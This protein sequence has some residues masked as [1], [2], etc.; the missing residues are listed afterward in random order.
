M[1]L[2]S[3]ALLQ[4]LLSYLGF[5]YPGRGL[6]LYSC[7][8]KAHSLLLT[9]DEGYL[10]TTAPPDL[11]CGIAPQGPPASTK[12]QNH[13]ISPLLSSSTANQ[14]SDQYI[15]Y[16]FNISQ[17]YPHCSHCISCFLYFMTELLPLL[18]CRP[19]PLGSLSVN[20]CYSLI[21]DLVVPKY[22]LKTFFCYTHCRFMLKYGK[23]NT[24][25]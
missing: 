10:L 21:V 23:T 8:S 5:S 20:Q 3:D 19:F 22:T 12:L 18:P 7:S 25:L 15:F 16:Y 6:S 1:C 17:V 9:L 13:L 4:H 11:E 14:L 2:P 24:I